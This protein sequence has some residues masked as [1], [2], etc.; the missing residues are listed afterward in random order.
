VLYSYILEP[1]EEELVSSSSDSE[2]E[3]SSSSSSTSG[4]DS[5]S[6]SDGEPEIT[7]EYLD[8]LIEKAKENARAKQ[9]SGKDNE[10]EEVLTLESERY[11]HLLLP[12]PHWA[13]SYRPIPS[14]DPGKLPKPYIEV[15]KSIHD[16]TVA[17]DP[18]AERFESQ[19]GSVLVP[20]PPIP[21][22]ELTKSGKPL[23][24]KEKKEVRK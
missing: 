17:R 2:S 18:D 5:D 12:S 21:P 3:S 22:P 8:S 4:S 20:Q 13:H 14:L 7:K 23:T 16:S 10:V 19:T 15:G 9:I 1:I 11:A 6:D 24:K